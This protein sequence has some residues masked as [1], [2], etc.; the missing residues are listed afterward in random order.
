MRK[1][2]VLLL[3]PVLSVQAQNHY[4]WF[5]PTHVEGIAETDTAHIYHR[6]PGYM[7]PQVREIVWRLSLNTAGE[8]IHFKTSSRNLIVRYQVEGKN[9]SSPH[10]PSTGFSGLDLYALDRHGNWN[11]AAPRYAFRDTISYTYA[12]MNLDAG[13]GSGDFYLY[14]PL[15]NTIKWLSIGVPE[16]ET[17]EFAPD[18]KEQPIVAYGTSIM[19]GAVASRPGMAWTNILERKLD[20]TVIN[21]G[22]S[23]N[24]KFE[25]PIFG[26][27]DKVDA[28]L[29]IF[30]CMPNL[31][32]TPLSILL[33]RIDTGLAVIRR[34]H[35]NT[36]VLLVEHADG[37]MPFAMD[38][39]VVNMYH[40]ASQVMKAAY[41][42]EL[43]KGWKGIYLLTEEEIG[44]DINSTVEGTHP[45]DVGMTKYADAYEKKIRAILGDTVGIISTE[46]PVEQYRDGFDW[47]ARH[48]A[49][50]DATATASVLLFGDSIINYWGGEPKAEKAAP[51]GEAAW[52]KYM[53]PRGIQNAGFGNDRIENVLWR[54][55][56]GELDNFGG[57]A[58]MVMIGTN[59]LHINT[60]AEIVDGLS[61]LLRQIQ[62]RK[63]HVQVI[64]AAI[65]PRRGMESRIE[66]LNKRIKQ[67][68]V[69]DHCRFADFS[70]A[71]LTGQRI[72]SALFLEDGL[73]P[74]E[75]GYEVLGKRISGFFSLKPP[76]RK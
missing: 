69:R 1:L 35:P 22:F 17:F 59:N 60:D 27:M 26:L 37:H 14:L 3:F 56:H 47:R 44:M 42:A 32:K 72:N 19:Q 8:F 13:K 49:V 4:K 21:L 51:K 64:M 41:Q 62:R 33:P 25:K 48:E 5:E 63:P 24:G 46:I 52:E 58:I 55:Y 54:I 31:S 34:D 11:W 71:L 67:M 40:G 53:L 57:S 28:R 74:N 61:F 73:H 18:K 75:K 23:G 76:M 39:T 20:R 12:N 68:A 30:D 50:A 70:P 36:P 2:I 66:M 6:L 15:Y 16:N 38:S 9:L 7:Q 10:M 43:A 45:S 29:Y 65:L